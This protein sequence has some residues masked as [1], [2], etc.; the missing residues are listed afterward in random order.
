HGGVAAIRAEAGHHAENRISPLA[1][2]YK[3]VEALEDN[4]F[5]SEMIA[6]SGILQPV[7][8]KGL[9]RAG[10]PPAGDI[11][12]ALV[13]PRLEEVELGTHRHVVLIDDLLHRVPVGED[14]IEALAD[15]PD[16]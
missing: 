12:D 4:V 11:V 6:V 7:V 15:L 8:H 14:G 16:L 10:D 2:R 5:L 3:I 9:L 13:D 1:E